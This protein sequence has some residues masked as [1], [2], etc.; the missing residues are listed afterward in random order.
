MDLQPAREILERVGHT[1]ATPEEMEVLTASVSEAQKRDMGLAY[2]LYV[3]IAEFYAFNDEPKIADEWAVQGL[4]LA[5]LD[6]E[7]HIY[8]RLV[9]ARA[10]SAYVIDDLV[11]AISLFSTGRAKAYAKQH[12]ADALRF[13]VGVSMCVVLLGDPKNALSILQEGDALQEHASPRIIFGM[14]RARALANIQLGQSDVA[15][16]MMLETDLE[17]LSRRDISMQQLTLG[18]AHLEIGDLDAAHIVIDSLDFGNLGL[19]WERAEYWLIRSD[20][21]WL[22]E[23]YQDALDHVAKVLREPSGGATQTIAAK[24]L[25]VRA[26]VLHAQGNDA[27]MWEAMNQSFDALQAATTDSIGC[28]VHAVVAPVLQEIDHLR[29]VELHT[30]HE[31]L[32]DTIEKLTQ[33][34]AHLADEAEE[35]RRTKEILTETHQDLVRAAHIAGMAEVATGVLHDLGN[36]LNSVGISID[37]SRRRI[38]NLA[39]PQIER[40]ASG[41]ADGSLNGPAAAAYLVK[42][43]AI[44]GETIANLRQE[45]ERTHNG[46]QHAA[47]IISA[48]QRNAAAPSGLEAIRLRTLVDDAVE[49][50]LGMSPNVHTQINVPDEE[51]LVTAPLRVVRILVNL[52]KNARD[53]MQKTPDPTIIISLTKAS[54]DG[55]TLD[56]LDT[57]PGIPE[58]LK[59]TVFRHGFTTKKDGSGFGLHASATSAGELGGSLSLE[60]TPVGQGAM[61]R[62][63]LPRRAAG[64]RVDVLRPVA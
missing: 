42:W 12:W 15:R 39:Q 33:A 22:G 30:A 59:A 24:A 62:L 37:M 1:M 5:T 46:L 49:L 45:F 35:H 28:A 63:I 52:L 55:L 60:D 51:E 16:R 9:F 58:H 27:G 56:I 64:T 17:P 23:R 26:R 7:P 19:A 61:F 3:T 43:A 41:L 21:A 34:N 32:V 36:A 8:F 29:S 31:A 44:R 40:V 25:R 54:E 11:Q 20:L 48:Q 18:R 50:A 6:N 57:G 47:R 13:T 10:I 14:D 38:T 53:A 4:T 2:R